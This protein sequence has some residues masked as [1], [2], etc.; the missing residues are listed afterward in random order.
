MDYRG[1]KSKVIDITYDAKDVPGGLKPALERLRKEA[2][3]AIDDGYAFIVL[4]DRAM[5]RERIAVSSLLACATVHHHLVST[6]KRTRIGLVLES[7]E[8]REVHHFCLLV[9]YGAD[10]INPYL[11]YE[12]LWQSQRDGLLEG[13]DFKTDMEIVDAYRKAVGKGMLKVMAKMGISTLASY[14]GAQIFEALGLR[15]EV[16]DGTFVD[17][18]SRL[19]GVGYDVLEEEGRRRHA[20]AYPAR[21]EDKLDELPN[22]GDFHWRSAGERHAWE[23]MTISNLQTAARTNSEAAYAKF[24]EQIN[25]NARANCTLRGLIDLKPRKRGS[26]PLEEVEPASEIVKRFVHRRYEFRF[27]LQGIARSA[28]R[29][30]EPSRWQIEHR[31]GR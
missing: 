14:K 29:G 12:A 28:R 22:P 11:A 27:H 20:L 4:S 23:P 7:G 30:D 8:A 25:D 1:M 17:T 18:V 15:D 2:E 26:I 3:R 6:S 24:A 16:I 9:G 19:Q 5:N 10:A 31:R 13:T 21:D